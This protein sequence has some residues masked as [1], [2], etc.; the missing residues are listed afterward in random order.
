LSTAYEED[1][2]ALNAQFDT[3]EALLKEIQAE[4]AAVR[5]A[6]EEQTLRID[7]TTEDVKAVVLDMREGESKTRDEMREMRDEVNNIREML[8]KVGC[9]ILSCVYSLHLPRWSTRTRT[10]KVNR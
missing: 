1:R 4:A 8:P 5:T 3:A 10:L 9:L 6:V 7:R 2:D